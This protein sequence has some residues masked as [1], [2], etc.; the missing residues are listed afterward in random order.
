M[1]KKKRY[2]RAGKPMIHTTISLARKLFKFE[3]IIQCHTKK[4]NITLKRAM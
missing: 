2:I 1:R 3:I 4:K